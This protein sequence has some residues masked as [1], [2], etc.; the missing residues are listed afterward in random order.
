[1]NNIQK[2]YK[3]LLKTKSKKELIERVLDLTADNANLSVK[4]EEL[5]EWIV[6]LQK[7][8]E[9]GKITI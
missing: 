7:M 6:N 9:D 2:W 5:Y 8:I 1:M 3:K 4:Y